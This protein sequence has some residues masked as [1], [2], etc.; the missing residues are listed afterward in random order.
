MTR[1]DRNASKHT[2]VNSEIHITTDV[3]RCIRCMRAIE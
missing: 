3:S 2:S 1:H